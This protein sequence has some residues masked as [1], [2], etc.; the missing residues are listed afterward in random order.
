MVL[1][2]KITVQSQ[3]YRKA[4]VSFYDERSYYGKVMVKLEIKD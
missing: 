4:M 3:Q 1:V 2:K